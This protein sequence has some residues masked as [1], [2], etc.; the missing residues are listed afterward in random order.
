MNIFKET[1]QKCENHLDWSS[2]N[3][4]HF[5][6]NLQG[7]EIREIIFEMLKKNFKKDN[8]NTI[9]E[10]GFGSGREY[11]RMREFFNEKGIEYTGLEYTKH[12]V[13]YAKKKYPK[14][15]WEQGDIRNMV[16]KDK[17]FDYIFLYHVLEHQN[18]LKDVEKAIKEMCKVAN[19]RIIIIWFK[20]P[21]L[22]DETRCVK[23]GAFFV[24]KY[25]AA[26]IW[27]IILQTDFV[28]KEI[29]W[30]NPWHNTIWNLEKQET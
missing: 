19:K 9:L 20:A 17:S 18:G 13:E 5:L 26:D 25:S 4:K 27:N 6:E 15:N 11:E 22:V 3:P 1:F 10:V 2:Y 28:V 14:A 24:Y 29:I 16:F 23:D 8:F 30:Q 12:F 21:S 7:Q